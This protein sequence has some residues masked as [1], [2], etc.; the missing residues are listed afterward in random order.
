MTLAI[1][2]VAAAVVA[3]AFVLR[4]AV[5]RKLQTSAVNLAQEIRPIDIEAFRNLV[6]PA[7]DEFLRAHLTAGQFRAVRRARLWAMVAYVQEAGRNAGFLVRIGQT[8]LA[9]NDARARE[10]A[11]RLV[12]DALLLRRN[13]TLA[14]VKI[15]MALAWP[16][17]GLA[18]VRIVQGYE[19][20]NGTAMLLGRLQ[21]PAVPVRVSARI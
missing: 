4:I 11:Q 20:M 2:L 15:Y 5:S 7:D 18:A 17:A 1:I 13:A 8:A 3:L 6:N 9:T 12:N 21:N 16:N 14:V 10:A 19:E